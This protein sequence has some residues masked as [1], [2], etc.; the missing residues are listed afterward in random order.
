MIKNLKTFTHGKRDKPHALGRVAAAKELG[1][2]RAFG[3]IWNGN[4]GNI[5]GAVYHPYMQDGETEHDL[6]QY[7]RIIH[8]IPHNVMVVAN[9]IFSGL[10]TQKDKDVHQNWPERFYNALPGNRDISNVPDQLIYNMLANDKWLAGYSD[11]KGAHLV[12]LITA[13]FMLRIEGIECGP[14]LNQIYSDHIYKLHHSRYITIGN[15]KE[16]LGNYAFGCARALCDIVTNPTGAIYYFLDQCAR[17][18]ALSD[19][20]DLSET[21]AIIADDFIEL[22]EGLK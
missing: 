21:W 6:W 2:F 14:R 1:M 16:K 15:N 18:R 8:G 9:N 5:T 20:R 22:L 11:E 10:S 19:K 4:C 13:I 12:G 7:P 3:R 17:G